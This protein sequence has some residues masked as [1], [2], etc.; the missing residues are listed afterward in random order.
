MVNFRKNQRNTLWSIGNTIVMPTIML[1][2]TPFFINKLGIEQYGIWAFITSI[3]SA[4]SILNLGGGEATI[5]FVSKYIGSGSRDD[6]YRVISTTLLL[7]VILAITSAFIGIALSFII[8]E[9]HLQ[10]ISDINKQNSTVAFRYSIG[11]FSLKLIEQIYVSVY[12]G[13]QRYD[14]ATKLNLLT[15]I[16]VTVLQVIV[17]A[18]GGSLNEIFKFSFYLVAVTIGLEHLFLVKYL[19]GFKLQIANFRQSVR[20]VFSF[21]LWAWIYSVLGLLSSQL[22]KVIIGLYVGAVELGYYSVAIIVYNQIHTLMSSSVSW[23]FPVISKR[24]KIDKE[25]VRKYFSFQIRVIALGTVFI[26]FVFIFRGEIFKLWL[27]EQTYMNSIGFIVIILCVNLL[28][29]PSIVPYFFL[30]GGG[31]IK[32]NTL[33]KVSIIIVDVIGVYFGYQIGGTIGI[34]LSKLISPIL[35]GGINRTYIHHKILKYKALLSGFYLNGI[36]YLLC[37]VFLVIAGG[38]KSNLG[39]IGVILFIIFGI[40][41]I[42]TL[43]FL[44]REVRINF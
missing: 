2:V 23:I 31:Y 38:L 19:K 41:I 44:K 40:F 27:G 24:N 14:S 3:T 29:L 34:L 7:N 30:N 8:G 20:E 43:F 16:I 37:S 26:L 39:S 11:I 17:V 32:L 33:L 28:N 13:F 6:V 21:G 36:T 5:K 15:K 12:K 42:P 35:I 1:I 4:F 10:N 22:D 9:G 25:L 18:S